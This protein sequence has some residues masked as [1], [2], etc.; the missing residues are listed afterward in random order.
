MCSKRDL[1]TQITV[2][3]GKW[4]LSIGL[5]ELRALLPDLATFSKSLKQRDQDLDTNALDDATDF[6]NLLDQKPA[7]EQVVTKIVTIFAQDFLQ[8]KDIHSLAN[9]L[10]PHRRNTLLRLASK[11]C[12]IFGTSSETRVSSGLLDA[13]RNGSATIL[14][15]FGGQG[16]VNNTA[17]TDLRALR[18]TYGSITTDLLNSA[19]ASLKAL[20]ASAEA[21]PFFAD[22]SLDVGLWLDE[23][24]RAPR[25]S[26]LAQAPISFP[27]I[28]LLSFLQFRIALKTAHLSPH[29]FRNS[30]SAMSG[31]SQGV[32]VA[33]V[34]SMSNTWDD[35]KH[36]VTLAI[37]TL[38]WIGLESHLAAPASRLP[39][40]VLASRQGSEGHPTPMLSIR[41][42]QSVL[43]E[44]YVK[45][46]NSNLPE[47]EQI[48]IALRNNYSNFV[49]AGPAHSLLGLL[50][51]VNS[52]SAVPDLDQS[53]VPH[54]ARK[55]VTSC[56]FLPISAPFHSVHLSDACHKVLA[57]IEHKSW[58][59]REDATRLIHTSSGAAVDTSN[60][61]GIIAQAVRMIMIEH[62]DWFKT[63]FSAPY[64][65]IVDFGPG[66]SSM[67]LRSAVEGSGTRPILIVDAQTDAQGFLPQTAFYRSD[68]PEPTL[69]WRDTYQARL[70]RGTSQCRLETKMT[71][72]LGL[73]PIMVAGMTPTTVSPE[74]VSAILR[75]G[76]HTELAGGGYTDPK[77]FE[78]AIKTITASLPLHQGLTCNLIYVSPRQI[79]WQIPLLGA[80]IAQGTRI[81]GLTIGGGVPS[82]DI[83]TEW[84]R[85]L[86][87]KH[88]TFKPGSISAIEQVLDIADRNADF[89][90]GLQWTGGRAGGH[91]SY[92]DFHEPILEMYA[93]IRRRPNVVLIAGGG[94]GDTASFVPYFT[95]QWSQ[96][97]QR[98]W[99]PFDGALIGSRVMAAKEA[100]SSDAVKELMVQASG[101]T[102]DQW[103]RSYV[104][105]VGGILTVLSEMGHPI[106][107]IANR[108][109]AFWKDMD[110]QIFSIRD[111]AS[112]LSKLTVHRQSIISRLNT[113]FAK[114]WFA[115]IGNDVMDLEDL[116]YGQCLERLVELMYVHSDDRWIDPSYRTLVSDWI[117]RI[118]QRLSKGSAIESPSMDDPFTA[119]DT[120][121]CQLPEME[122]TY[123]YYEDVAYFMNLCRRRGQKP[124]NFVPRLD[125]DFETWFKKDSL[126][127]SEDLRAVPGEDAQRVCIIFG[128]VAAQFT[129][130][131]NEPVG[132]LL[133]NISFSLRD[134]LT[135]KL[136]LVEQSTA[137]EKS[138]DLQESIVAQVSHVFVESDLNNGLEALIRRLIPSHMSW[139]RACLTDRFMSRKGEIVSNSIKAAFQPRV[140]DKLD[141]NAPR[142]GPQSLVLTPD[143]ARS[144]RHRR[145]LKIEYDPDHGIK[146]LLTSPTCN[147]LEAQLV[148]NFLSKIQDGIVYIHET[149]EGRDDRI[150]TFYSQ[151]WA[152][153]TI[154][155]LDQCDQEIV[156]SHEMVGRYMAS[157][158]PSADAA[159]GYDRQSGRI[160]IDVCI[161]VAWQALMSGLLAS[162]SGGNIFRLLHRTASFTYESGIKVL[163]IGDRVSTS[164]H[165]TALT[166]LQSGRSVCVKVEVRRGDKLVVTI[167]SEF[168]IL[169]VF[170][171]KTID[172]SIHEEPTTVIAV[173]SPKIEALLRSRTWL[174]FHDPQ[175]KHLG[176]ALALTARTVTQGAQFESSGTIWTLQ[177]GEKSQEIG[178]ICLRRESKVK[179]PVVPFLRRHGRPE[180][181]R[182]PLEKPG[183]RQD[184]VLRC[185]IPDT[186]DHYSRAS[187]DVNPIHTCPYFAGLAGLHQPIAHGMFTSAAVRQLVE[188][189]AAD[190]DS[191]RFRSW[192]CSFDAMVLHG[193]ELEVKVEHVAMCEGRMILQV[194]AFNV[195]S[196]EQVLH[197]EAEI[198]Q[199]PSAYVFCGQGSQEKG[200]GM[201]LYSSDL[202]AKEFWDRGDKHLQRIYGKYRMLVYRHGY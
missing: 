103:H 34:L 3:A 93:S 72:M 111:P 171:D 151:L 118:T 131:A 9:D 107:V 197:A 86:G 14:A 160:P 17:L 110:E 63:C 15:V 183:W 46:A 22:E 36:N 114:P 1:P 148:F 132:D 82:I 43:V 75:A 29:S 81:E 47:S 68:P 163:R 71:R 168:S 102:D 85:T 164:S 57:R 48:H 117:Q 179:C 202:V 91:H 23:P 8:H 137:D 90:I 184:E 173:D 113:D 200:M 96:A 10:D 108:A 80:L 52:I 11:Y 32:L 88:I 155:P 74:F 190:G 40:Q 45:E 129:K 153:K 21:Q 100:R 25:I 18:E 141:I 152:C 53:R 176:S 6:I 50:E 60:K 170:D 139:A 89:P 119:I 84:I 94:F 130:Q 126:W 147:D 134:K 181:Q 169:G 142:I 159:A 128:P 98:P 144:H 201:P 2:S 7:S 5:K 83:A 70:V 41:G 161:V 44:K 157:I 4:R 38:F 154:V 182:V 167:T 140:H 79:A 105:S 195:E 92:E 78:E 12:G 20:S 19:A 101:C 189:A 67:L 69:S 49:V 39:S 73:Q 166:T 56:S 177:K 133:D 156:I 97:Y 162:G 146:L 158:A 175:A 193:Q 122:T 61:H 42:L 174:R 180:R 109:M 16:L 178:T 188:R 95:G 143:P 150:W 196:T 35:F 149:T 64:S 104:Q 138:S 187:L 186:G 77:R 191:T 120:V 198:E 199:P 59:I 106:H 99:M 192:S 37:E 115:T 121:R 127:Q 24:S 27:L 76:Y 124:V 51:T 165:V 54:P 28:G 172:F 13:A 33:A 30:L 62:V 66:R 135:H 116:T 65:H 26:R 31:H 145:P 194:K 58:I 112:R 55:P 136:C 125:A 87:L 123:L 185:R